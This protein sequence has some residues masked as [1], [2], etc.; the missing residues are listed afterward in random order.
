MIHARLQCK[1]PTGWLWLILLCLVPA[2]IQAQLGL[3]N[4]SSPAAL[5]T[6][7]TGTFRVN[8][9]RAGNF[10][11]ADSVQLDLLLPS[12]IEL[13]GSWGTT[14]GTISLAAGSTAQHPLF[15]VKNFPLSGT[16]SF[17]FFYD[18]RAACGR[19]SPSTSPSLL[20]T[21]Q[22]ALNTAPFQSLNS[23]A[24]NVTS[25]WVVFD[26]GLS[27]NLNYTGAPFLVPYVRTYVFR[28]TSPVPFTG[29]FVWRDTVEF[30]QT[31]TALRIDAA[32]VAHPSLTLLSSFV[33]DSTAEI[34]ARVVGLVQGDSIVVRETVRLV[35]CPN[36][37]NFSSAFMSFNY[38]CINDANLCIATPVPNFQTYGIVTG[39]PG[40]S[41]NELNAAGNG[42]TITWGCPAVPETRTVMMRNS[43]AS[44]S[45]TLY[46]QV[47]R[48]AYNNIS[49]FNS[50][51]MQLYRLVNGSP[52][53]L[54]PTRTT[55][56]Y[57]YIPS[58][59]IDNDSTTP[60]QMSMAFAGPFLPNDTV[61]LTYIEHKAC[62][63]TSQY[64]FDESIGMNGINEIG[65][66]GHPCY[67]TGWVGLTHSPRGVWGYTIQTFGLQQ[68]FENH[69]AFL[70]DMEEAWMNIDNKTPLTMNINHPYFPNEVAVDPSGLSFQVEI[71]IEQGLG[72]IDKQIYLISNQNGLDSIWYPDNLTFNLQGADT[73]Q[74]STIIA[75]FNLPS[76]FFLPNP[77]G[78][79]TLWGAQWRKSPSFD[80]FFNRFSVQ[81]KVGSDCRF[82]APN[83][84]AAIT[85][86]TF[87]TYDDN[88]SPE[89]RFPLSEVGDLI[90]IHCPGCR[91]PGWNLDAL[92]LQRINFGYEDID[93]DNHPD[94]LTVSGLPTANAVAPP[95][96]ER[97]VMIGDTLRLNVGGFTSDGEVLLFN[98]IGFD[99]RYAWFKMTGD[100]NNKVDFIGGHGTLNGTTFTLP[101]NREINTVSGMY[102]DL[103]LDTLASTVTSG[104]LPPRFW[105][106]DLI[107]LELD[108]VVTQNMVNGSSY[109]T[110]EDIV[111]FIEMSGVPRTQTV[112]DAGPDE[113]L[114]L[115]LTPAQRAQY[116][117]WCTGGEGRI[118]G[119]GSAFN[120]SVI[121]EAY[122]GIWGVTGLDF[123]YKKLR[124][125][126]NH[127]VGEPLSS[128]FWNH[129]VA[130]QTALNSF[131]YE[132]RDFIAVDS[133]SY[134]L[135]AGWEVARVDIRI[136]NIMR[137]TVSNLTRYISA[138]DWY[139]PFHIPVSMV[140]HN[141]NVATI[142]PHQYY[143][144]ISDPAVYMANAGMNQLDHGD[145]TKRIQM[146]LILKMTDCE[147]TPAS[148]NMGNGYPVTTYLDN[149]PS[150]FGDTMILRRNMPP[151]TVINRPDGQLQAQIL[152]ANLNTSVSNLTWGLNLSLPATPGS[153]Y[154]RDWAANTFVYAYSPSGNINIT[155]VRQPSSP[156]YF[157]GL[158]RVDTIAGNTLFGLGHFWQTNFVNL[159]M[160]GSYS[161]ADVESVDSIYV[162]Y[163]WNCYGYPSSI[164]AACSKDTAVAYVYPTVAGLQ[165]TLSGP[166]TVAVCDTAEY[167]LRLNATGIGNL[168]HVMATLQPPVGGEWTYVPGST[169]AWFGGAPVAMEPN[170]GLAWNLDTIP[171]IAN[172]FNSAAGDVFIRFKVRFNCDYALEPITLLL[173]GETYCGRQ[174]SFTRTLSP[175]GLILPPLNT[176]NISLSNLSCG[177]PGGV[178]F[179][180]NTAAVTQFE[181][182][183]TVTLPAG[184]E[185]TGGGGS[186]VITI[187]AGTAAGVQ[188]FSFGMEAVTT[189]PC[190]SAHTLEVT[191][192]KGAV[193]QCNPNESPCARLDVA[194]TLSCSFNVSAPTVS[195]YSDGS[196]VAGCTHLIPVLSGGSG[197][198]SY[199]WTET[200]ST[201]VLSTDSIASLCPTL[202]S[203]QYTLVVTDANGCSVSASYTLARCCYPPVLTC[204]DT[205]IGY[206][207]L[208]CGAFVLPEPAIETECAI[209]SITSDW[210]GGPFPVGSTLVTWTVVNEFGDTSQC[211]HTVTYQPLT[212]MGVYAILARDQVDL[213]PN[214]LV[215]A[216]GVGVSNAGG[217]AYLQNMTHVSGTG[218]FVLA[219]AI[220]TFPNTVVS[221]PMIGQALPSLP[222]MLLNP[223]TTGPD[224]TVPVNGTVTLT[225][226]NYGNISLSQGSTVEFNG[227]S[228]VY[229][230]N[231]VVHNKAAGANSTIRFGQCTD[232]AVR[233]RIDWGSRVN[234][235]PTG[236]EVTF[237][238][239]GT[240]TSMQQNQPAVDVG[241]NAVVDAD[242]FVPDGHLFVHSGSNTVPASMTGFY[243]GRWV[244]GQPDIRW[245]N[246]PDC[247]APYN[248][249]PLANKAG[250]ED[251]PAGSG[252]AMLD[253]WPN[254]VS[255][256]ASVRFMLP[257]SGALRLEVLNL[258][259]QLMG[260]LFEG[261]VNGAQEY[262]VEFRRE[263]LPAGVYLLRLQSGETQITR[264]MVVL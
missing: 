164:E 67:P 110:V 125:Q 220:T 22:A 142:Y 104:T 9:S 211:S 157:A 70:N 30:D 10:T 119:I 3:S 231:F 199:S 249:V 106:M 115:S 225:G 241:P 237:Y 127:D 141:G 144:Y 134:T 163:G 32:T 59:Y 66:F 109:F 148:V 20:N 195:L 261:E 72:L 262:R 5:T 35:D 117:Y 258:N 137:D 143:D 74:G 34:R 192:S 209:V 91:V 180:L 204:A 57:L 190:P 254:P 2:G 245:T 253:Y 47:S 58:Y 206:N 186:Q 25:A 87:L 216:G 75:T 257:V 101:G 154:D 116:F 246:D 179:D 219:P 196:C 41:M 118:T 191:L 243:Y 201:T 230:Q 81:F 264:R 102:I 126:T 224:V 176:D 44:A 76:Y 187:A 145:E 7:G 83:S 135:P 239:S 86:R 19:F 131:S 18:A 198:F 202:D 263:R 234:V 147:T 223:N 121:S 111:G 165:D 208:L 6:C 92:T 140:S 43:G 255:E 183:V 61:Y 23:G 88:C 113:S 62:I 63:D 200:G 252:A 172:G 235:N 53:Y 73:A 152:P 170:A 39:A 40:I 16:G 214:N 108:F 12:G 217:L 156:Y 205:V 29:D 221:N 155:N 24:Y 213:M 132:V 105:A 82:V 120:H 60:Y 79:Y 203:V 124:S 167:T 123:C 175:T 218:S 112:G 189:V 181:N 65:Q 158:P 26:P 185:F 197:Q 64:R 182:S 151:G 250:L 171:A 1:S 11:A 36:G 139:A 212:L 128:A 133:I 236:E 138:P 77:S 69:T 21:V 136:S 256:S 45:D 130:N 100:I 4:L 31:Q 215:M 210:A 173:E 161:C 13:G 122:D 17:E 107:D 174:I 85:Q 229:V 160:D 259:G 49:Y 149:V 51:E 159:S 71:S 184:F 232:V 153:W 238:V 228:T 33:N 8:I 90:S 226:N 188:H 37:I 68:V 97:R 55:F 222:P 251:T 114:I 56:Q 38:G 78:A 193:L 177:F 84:L 48:P 150:Q 233:Q 168:Y 242:I 94:A 240:N 46:I 80:K 169:V 103:S 146:D 14:S 98:N 95:A 162:I 248:C 227:Q 207:Q 28:N 93:N 129:D 52:V 247:E 89:C 27:Q 260:S 99:Y 244:T 54:T 15:T 42:G 178:S 50:S 166:T 96:R 194:Q